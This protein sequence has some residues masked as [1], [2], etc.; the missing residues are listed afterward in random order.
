[1]YIVYAQ[2]VQ[3]YNLKIPIVYSTG[4]CKYNSTLSLKKV[5]YNITVAE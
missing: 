1:M 3:S 2:V 4:Q 5:F